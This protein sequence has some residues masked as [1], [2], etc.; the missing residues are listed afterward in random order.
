MWSIPHWQRSRRITPTPK[1][2]P[3]ITPPAAARQLNAQRSGFIV[4]EATS[5]PFPAVMIRR[6]RA[7]DCR[8][9]L[10]TLP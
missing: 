1:R 2:P 8:P 9:Y 5:R 4:G 6:W 10:F 3:L 7:A